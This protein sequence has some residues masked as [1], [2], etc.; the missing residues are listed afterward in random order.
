MLNWTGL[1]AYHE[2]QKQA[3]KLKFVEIGAQWIIQIFAG[4]L[5]INMKKLPIKAI[6]ADKKSVEPT[7]K[8]SKCVYI[9]GKNIS[10]HP[11]LPI[12]K[13]VKKK[14]AFLA[15]KSTKALALSP[16]C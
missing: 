11:I 14:L 2:I 6:F 4:Q 15:E 5:F 9:N 8:V 1:D 12:R 7:L 3:F 16:I 10:L 13:H